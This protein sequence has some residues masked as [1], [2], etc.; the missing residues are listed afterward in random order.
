MSAAKIDGLDLVDT[1]DRT[2]LTQT[3]LRQWVREVLRPA[4]DA[5]QE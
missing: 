5:L 1:P 3:T 2:Q 4:V